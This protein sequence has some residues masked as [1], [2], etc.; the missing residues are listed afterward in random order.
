MTVTKGR[1]VRNLQFVDGAPSKNTFEV[2]CDRIQ[3]GGHLL[4]KDL[5]YFIA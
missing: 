5:N 1:V 3:N 2:E 4:L